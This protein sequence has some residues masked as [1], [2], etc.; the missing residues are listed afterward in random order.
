LRVKENMCYCNIKSD[1]LKRIQRR[2][3]W[4]G[5]FYT[6]VKFHGKIPDDISDLEI[7]NT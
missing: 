3:K 4:K 2:L 5:N 7:I 1:I 6:S